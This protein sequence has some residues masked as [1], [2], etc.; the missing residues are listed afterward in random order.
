MK[1]LRS[2]GPV[3][4]ENEAFRFDLGVKASTLLSVST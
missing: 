1:I 3:K 4:E 2:K